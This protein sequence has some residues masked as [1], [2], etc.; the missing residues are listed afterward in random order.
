M[1]ADLMQPRYD[2]PNRFNQILKMFA[3]TAI[4]SGNVPSIPSV[5]RKGHCMMLGENGVIILCLNYRCTQK[6]HSEVM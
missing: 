2:D 6:T 4:C 5:L 3:Q 1:E